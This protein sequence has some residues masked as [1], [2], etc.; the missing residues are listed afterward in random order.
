MKNPTTIVYSKEPKRQQAIMNFI[1]RIPMGDIQDNV[2][3]AFKQ[4]FGYAFDIFDDKYAGEIKIQDREIIEQFKEIKE[5]IDTFDKACVDKMSRVQDNSSTKKEFAKEICKII[6]TSHADRLVRFISYLYASCANTSTFKSASVAAFN[7]PLQVGN[8][9]Y[10]FFQKCASE[11]LK[12]KTRGPQ[13]CKVE[14]DDKDY[15]SD[16]NDITHFKI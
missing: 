4:S 6:E 16:T 10:N 7:N 5:K 2:V 13:T 11:S 8:R 9:T 12:P 15:Q 14:E 1:N 3:Y